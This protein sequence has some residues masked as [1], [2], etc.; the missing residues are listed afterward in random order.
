M[1]ID[2]LYFSFYFWRYMHFFDKKVLGKS[3]NSNTRKRQLKR[4]YVFV[5]EI[6]GIIYF[7]F[8][9]YRITQ[10]VLE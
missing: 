9:L 10:N 5:K 1:N 2:K 4:D 3:R 7:H 8:F 6:L